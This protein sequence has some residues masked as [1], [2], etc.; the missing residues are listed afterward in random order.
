MP[1][2]AVFGKI[3]IVAEKAGFF[4]C[5]RIIN[6]NRTGGGNYDIHL[7]LVRKDFVAQDNSIIFITYCNI[8]GENFEPDF[9]YADSSKYN[10]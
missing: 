1:S 10:F 3:I 7:V 6:L 9:L 4:P 5:Q 2:A 8:L